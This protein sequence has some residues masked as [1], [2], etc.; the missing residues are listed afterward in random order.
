[1][2]GRPKGSYGTM[3]GPGRELVSYFWYNEVFLEGTGADAPFQAD[4]PFS[5]HRVGCMVKLCTS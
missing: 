4:R 2:D 1:M 3:C 5:N